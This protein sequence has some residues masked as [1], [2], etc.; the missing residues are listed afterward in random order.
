MQNEN[1]LSSQ[2]ATPSMCD[3]TP[4]D[5]A[6]WTIRVAE[7]RTTGEF[8]V[9]G[10]VPADHHA[11]DAGGD[12]TGLPRRSRDCLGTNA[13][14]KGEQGL[15]L[16]RH[17]CLASRPGRNCDIRR[18]IAQPNTSIYDVVRRAMAQTAGSS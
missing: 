16:A 9:S 1:E 2:I 17:A 13:I 18:A 3:H 10:P 14:S 5:L 4:G 7:H 15:G 6:E 11:P 12:R 8:N